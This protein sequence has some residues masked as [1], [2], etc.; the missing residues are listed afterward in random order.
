MNASIGAVRVI[1]TVILTGVVPVA[2]FRVAVIP[3]AGFRIIVIVLVLV[4][5]LVVVEADR[6]LHQVA[7]IGEQR[8]R[9]QNAVNLAP[10]PPL[11][12]QRPQ[13][14]GLSGAGRSVQKDQSADKCLVTH[15]H[16]P[17]ECADRATGV[18]AAN[19]RP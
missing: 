7:G 14:G 3:V 8:L 10:T 18:V 17:V 13:D 6:D 15:G 4:L 2:G 9:V 19:R 16:E 12:G 5:V 11:M 1:A